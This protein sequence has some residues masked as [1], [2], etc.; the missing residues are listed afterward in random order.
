[1]IVS[2][3]SKLV[4]LR[5]FFAKQSFFQRIASSLKKTPRND[6][7]RNSYTLI[8]MLL[9]ASILSTI[10][11]AVF[12][13]LSS[14]LNIWERSRKFVV[15]EDIAIFF[16]KIGEDLRNSFSYSKMPF[17]GKETLLRFP[18]HIK[19]SRAQDEEILEGMGEVEYYFDPDKKSLTRRQLSYGQALRGDAGKERLVLSA[20]L[21]HFA[22]YFLEGNEAVLKE[23]IGTTMPR[24][25]AVEVDFIDGRQKRTFRKL[26]NL[27]RG[28]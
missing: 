17:A 13:A 8:E 7:R 6:M 2:V 1:M 28:I 5:A 26:I 14:G 19:I 3:L 12:H 21:V 22:Y 24:A 23:E 25:V 10:S 27:P 18:T 11:L 20:A 9:V 4:S 16:D 15:E